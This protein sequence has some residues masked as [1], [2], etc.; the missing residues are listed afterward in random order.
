MVKLAVGTNH[1]RNI[2][3]NAMRQALISA[4]IKSTSFRKAGKSIKSPRQMFKP[5]VIATT[6]RR[7]KGSSI[8]PVQHI[9]TVGGRSI[10]V[11]TSGDIWEFINEGNNFLRAIG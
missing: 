5:L 11:T 8:Q 10:A 3:M 2:L 9:S 7:F 4:N 6:K 1:M